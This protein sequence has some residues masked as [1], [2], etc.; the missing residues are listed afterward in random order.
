M[1]RR[2]SLTALA[3]VAALVVAAAPAAAHSTGAIVTTAASIADTL[4]HHQLVAAAPLPS[5]SWTVLALLAALTLAAVTRPRR[6]VVLA[7]VLVV[8]V[9]AFET[10]LHAAHHVGDD[11][12]RCVVAS[13]SSQL[14]GTTLAVTIDAAPAV[15]DEA[16]ISA[17]SIV[18][19]AGRA[20]APDAGRAPPA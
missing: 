6:A 13:M 19:A 2:L 10:G 8:G 1:L 20:L 17:P 4:P 11:S 7:L 14:H 9:L 12:A 3:T 5:L 18:R 16:R 15:V